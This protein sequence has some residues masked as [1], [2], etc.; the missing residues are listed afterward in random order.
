MI[1]MIKINLLPVKAAKRREQGQR[2]LLVGAVVFTLAL[3]G[4]IV[5]HTAAAAKITDLQS[6]NQQTS[7]AIA[8]L[9]SEIGDY[10]L[11]KAQRDELIRQRDAIKRL[12]ANRAGPVF[13][14]RELSDILTKG[15]G[16]T[17]NKEQYEEALKRDPNAGFNPNWEPKRVWLLGY[18][19]HNHAVKIKGAAKSDED[20]AEFLKRLK[21]S[22]FFS[23]V[24][25]QQTQPQ[26]DSRLNVSYVTFD[27]T[28]RVNY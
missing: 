6:Q 1:F 20:V 23:D 2:Q 11:V 17:F 14:L 15:K 4:I 19:E 16:P 12:Q 9:K 5:F 26:F 25:W 8:R 27:V 18:E 22:A 24:Y 10:E 3:V 28:C 7:A 13:L 21:V